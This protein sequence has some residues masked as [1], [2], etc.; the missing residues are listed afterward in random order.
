[1]LH[2]DFPVERYLAAELLYPK[3]KTA[4]LRNAISGNSLSSIRNWM[5]QIQDL[6]KDGAVQSL[7]AT[8]Y[9]MLV[10]EP[11]QNFSESP[12]ESQQ[13][14][15]RL[16]EKPDSTARVVLAY[17]DI[18]QAED[19]RNY[20]QDAWVAPKDGLRGSPDFLVAADPDGWEGNYP[21]AYWDPAWQS[22]WLGPDGIVADLARLGFDGVFLDWIEAYDDDRVRAVAE[23]AGISPEAAMITFVEALGEAGRTINPDFLIVAQNAMYLIDSDPD[24]YAKAIDALAVESTWFN[25]FGD[26]DWDDSDSG[27][28]HDQHVAEYSTPARLAQILRYQNAGLPVFSVDYALKQNNVTTVYGEAQSRGIIPLVTRVSLSKLT[29]TPPPNLGSE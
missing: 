21:V 15:R 2:I 6:N 26:S 14:V 4:S 8:N 3:D 23:K 5:Y 24:R 10:I 7:A 9:D 19:Y 18:G 25:G 22:L 11:G 17:I 13:M 29:E 1:M 20:W 28:Q 27:D 16:H 12:Y